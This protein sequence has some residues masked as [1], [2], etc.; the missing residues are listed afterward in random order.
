MDG[1]MGQIMM[2][3]G[4][5]PPRNW[6]FCQGQVLSITAN[7]ALFSLLGVTYG[8]DGRTSF[9]LPNLMARVPVGVNDSSR[10]GLMEYRLGETG[11]VE[12]NILTVKQLP[13]YNLQASVKVNANSSNGT[14]KEPTGNY[15]AATVYS[16]SRTDIKDINSYSPTTN[17]EMN[18]D[19]VNIT[20]GSKGGGQGIDNLQP[21]LGMHYIICLQ[22]EYPARND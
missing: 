2:F 13:S 17:V 19:A 12:T 9:G 14:T 7:T 6:A 16:V 1:T 22:G 5:F 11:G 10:Q 4:T 15:P 20:V 18:P 8:G 21:F 3:A